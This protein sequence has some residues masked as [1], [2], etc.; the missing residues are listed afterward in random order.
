MRNLNTTDVDFKKKTGLWVYT[1]SAPDS[2]TMLN[3]GTHV[4]VY[5]NSESLIQLPTELSISFVLIV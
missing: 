5:I 1:F 4:R 3:F 2:V